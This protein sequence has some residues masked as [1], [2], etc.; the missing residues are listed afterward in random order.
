MDPT[1]RRRVRPNS[2]DQSQQTALGKI[3]QSIVSDIHHIHRRLNLIAWLVFGCLASSIRS[4]AASRI[5]LQLEGIPGESAQTSHR[6]WIDLNQ[7]FWSS[8]R[9]SA[10][11]P[12]TA[13][14]L[15]IIKDLDRSSPTLLEHCGTGQVIPSAVMHFSILSDQELILY[16]IKLEG[17][18]LIQAQARGASRGPVDRPVEE[19]SLSYDRI[20]WTVSQY[21]LRGL[22]VGDYESFWDVRAGT[23]GSTPLPVILNIEGTAKRGWTVSWAGEQGRA[24]VLRASAQAESGYQPVAEAVG[25]ENGVIQRNFPNLGNLR[26]FKLETVR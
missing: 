19:M 14:P 18:R 25:V 5:Y 1:I 7:F 22:K 16:R 20:Q 21:D 13:E 3:L 9:A 15:V 11:D 2:L 8:S 4:E 17:V 24:Y 23:A 26:F 12:P 6:G 10:V